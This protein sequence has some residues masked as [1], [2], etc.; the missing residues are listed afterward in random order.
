MRNMCKVSTPGEEARNNLCKDVLALMFGGHAADFPAIKTS[1][2]R[3]CDTGKQCTIGDLSIPL[4]LW[5]TQLEFGSANYDGCK[6][7]LLLYCDICADRFAS[8]DACVMAISPLPC[9]VVCVQGTLLRVYGA[10]VM[11]DQEPGKSKDPSYVYAEILASVDLS[12]GNAHE[13]QA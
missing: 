5:Q 7:A 6:Q 9:L 1:R 11:L 12:T 10:A 3:F 4:I 8:A 2:N 13:V